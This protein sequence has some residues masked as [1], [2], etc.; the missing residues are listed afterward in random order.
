ML[1]EQETKYIDSNI[2]NVFHFLQLRGYHNF[3]IGSHSIRNILYANDYDLNANVGVT[4]SITVLH[5]LYKEFVSIFKKAHASPD[6]YILDFKCG[7]YEG[8]PIRWSYNDMLEGK[9]KRGNN[10]ITFEECLLMDDNTIKLDLCYIYNDIFTDINC[11]YNLFIVKNKEELKA[12]K[13]TQQAE[14]VKSLRDEIKELE[15][16]QE[17]F[18]AMKRYFSLGIIEGKVDDDILDLL[19]SEYGILYKFISFLKLVIEMIDQDFKPIQIDIIRK[20]LEYIKQFL[21]HIVKININPYL[22]RLIKI[23]KINSLVKMKIALEKLV[24][25]ASNLLNKE[26]LTIS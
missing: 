3:L 1:K 11:L 14:T 12:S 22:N 9:V 4:D 24:K 19:N 17:Y 16:N 15:G 20:N 2:E 7:I 6:Y 13:A 25:D 10:E 18:K 8:E 26:I 5:S 21:S 23:I